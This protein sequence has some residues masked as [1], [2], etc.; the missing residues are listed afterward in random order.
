LD[1]RERIERFLDRKE[2]RA[3][4]ADCGPEQVR[5]MVRDFLV[6]EQANNPELNIA[7]SPP[8]KRD[9]RLIALGAGTLAAIGLT[10]WKAPR[11]LLIPLTLGGAF[12]ATLLVKEMIDARQLASEPP[13]PDISDLVQREDVQVQNQM[14]HIALVKP[15]PFRRWTLKAVLTSVNFLAETYWNKGKLGDIP[16]IH[17]ARWMLIDNDRRLLFFSNFDGSWE[18]YLGDFVDR[19]SVGLTGVWS[20]TQHFPAARWLVFEG[21]RD[22]DRFKAWTRRHQVPTQ[23]WYSAHP[24][25]TVTNI[26]N[27]IAVRDG[28]L[29]DLDPAATE[30]W[31]RRL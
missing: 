12:T 23:V 8:A 27:A 16:T 25:Y 15:G 3:K 20:N 24:D 5:A 9:L 21:A 30:E 14:T 1:V 2:V 18:N 6:R 4:T 28:A 10:A 31:L 19:A 13:P 29:R 7:P 17:F 26:L 11:A 22:V